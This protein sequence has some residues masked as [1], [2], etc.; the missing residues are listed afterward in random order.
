MKLAIPFQNQVFYSIANSQFIL[1]EYKKS[2]ENYS[3]SIK[4]DPDEE[5][6]YLNRGNAKFKIN[7]YVESIK[8]YES[9]NQ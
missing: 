7:D 8:D 5:N 4:Y 3:K 2:I 1:L 9:K 6:A